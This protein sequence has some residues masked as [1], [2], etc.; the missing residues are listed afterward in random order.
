MSLSFITI[1]GSFPPSS[2]HTGINVFAAAAATFFP[3]D[4]LPVKATISTYLIKF[5]P[6]EPSP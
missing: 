2:R 1:A 3:V 6:V 4:T 5:A